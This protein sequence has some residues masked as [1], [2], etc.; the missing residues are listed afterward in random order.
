[1]QRVVAD[2][3]PYFAPLE[4]AIRS[5]FIPALLGIKSWEV[6]G[7]YRELLTHGVKQGGLA[8]RNP[9]DAALH[10]HVASK[11]ATAHLTTSLIDDTVIFDLGHHLDTARAAGQVARV[12]RLG[13][14]QRHLDQRGKD[15]PAIKQRELQSCAA[16]AWLTVVPNCLNGTSLLAEEWRDNVHLRY[17]LVPQVMPHHCDGCGACKTGSLVHIRHD[18]VAD[19]WRHL[20]TLAFSAG[21]VERKPRIFSSAGRL[22]RAVGDTAEVL[23]QQEGDE[24]PT[25]ERGDI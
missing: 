24:S 15:A 17:N 4:A 18:D 3:G 9:V 10:V 12:A 22:A 19:K 25:E 23:T 20:C 14:E 5:K 8:L 21:Q 1:M 13:R 7:G 6:D 16:G 11:A 2:T